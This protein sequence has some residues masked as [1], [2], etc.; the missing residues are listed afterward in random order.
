MSDKIFIKTPVGRVVG[1][2]LYEP[3]TKD[4]L[5]NPLVYKTGSNVGQARVEYYL[6]LAIEKGAEAHW[7]QTHWGSEIWS[8]GCSFFAPKLNDQNSQFAQNFAWKI[9]DGDSAVANSKGIAP[10]SRPGYPRHWILNLTSGFAPI[11]HNRDGSETITTKDYVNLG[12]YIQ[13]YISV[14]SNESPNVNSG[15]FL[16]VLRVAF[17][18]Y[19]ERIVLGVDPRL[20]GFGTD[21]LPAGACLTPI[22]P[23][24]TTID[25]TTPA[26]APPPAPV[27]PPAPYVQ[28]L[29][30]PKMTEKANGVPYNAYVAQ[31]WTDDMLRA[32]GYML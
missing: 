17:Q 5:G 12:D 20:I 29:D 7:S 31:G 6:A 9:T 24:R 19:G 8:A 10:A 1:G 18:A 2:S 16:N 28:I 32:Q 25:M 3:N 21:P 27:P 15:I 14:G 4:A 30:V 26:I 22:A 13:T 23:A 11:V